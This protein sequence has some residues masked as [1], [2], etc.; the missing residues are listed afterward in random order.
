MPITNKV[1]LTRKLKLKPNESACVT[2][3]GKNIDCNA[4]YLF[5]SNGNNKS[6]QIMDSI[7]K[8]NKMHNKKDDKDSYN[9]FNIYVHNNSKNVIH[10]NKN[11]QLGTVTQLDDIIENNIIENE[12]TENVKNVNENAIKEIVCLIQASD[13]ILMQRK[14]D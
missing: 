10:L 7:I 13:D 1:S 9:E 11:L 12:N 2:I 5:E 6:L 4:N 8:V 3:K 14:N